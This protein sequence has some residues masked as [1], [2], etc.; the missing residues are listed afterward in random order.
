M[1]TS[2]HTIMKTLITLK[3]TALIILRDC[4]VICVNRI[5][6]SASFFKYN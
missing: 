1:K 6:E 2:V 3:F 5:L 4:K